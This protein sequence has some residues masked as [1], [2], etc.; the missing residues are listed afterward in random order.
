MTKE[1]SN[2]KFISIYSVWTNWWWI[3]MLKNWKSWISIYPG[4]YNKL[5][6]L[7]NWDIVF[8]IQTALRKAILFTF[9]EYTEENGIKYVII[10]EED[11]IEI[12]ITIAEFK[13]LYFLNIDSLKSWVRSPLWYNTNLLIFEQW[14]DILEEYCSYEKLKKD[15]INDLDSLQREYIFSISIDEYISD[16]WILRSKYINKVVC[17]VNEVRFLKEYS[18]FNKNW[19]IPNNKFFNI[20]FSELKLIYWKQNLRNLD[21]IISNKLKFNFYS[22][23]SY[24]DLTRSWAETIWIPYEETDIEKEIEKEENIIAN[25]WENRKEEMIK[26]FKKLESNYKLEETRWLVISILFFLFLF[27]I[28][29]IPI[30]S[31]FYPN[32]LELLLWLS[33]E[34]IFFFIFTIIYSLSKENEWGS[35]KKIWVLKKYTDLIIFITLLTF[36]IPIFFKLIN[37]WWLFEFNFKENFYIFIPITILNSIFI[38]FSV[39]QFSKAKNLRI[40]FENRIAL[41]NWY[42]WLQD[43]QEKNIDLF[44]AKTAEIVFSKAIP[45]KNDKDLPVDQIVSLIKW[46]NWK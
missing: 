5:N 9:T 39:Y 40:E 17:Q 1:I 20:P 35:E 12:E 11:K 37:S 46:I 32:K 29:F 10:N 30:F 14:K 33:I 3:D 13:N 42:L 8:F 44:W 38:Y 41:M 6:E 26:W 19:I 24:Y 25:R 31:V 43:M 7:K 2:P 22:F 18:V 45:D 28:S 16:S 36:N 23:P 15:L 27:V 21:K 34:L 4:S